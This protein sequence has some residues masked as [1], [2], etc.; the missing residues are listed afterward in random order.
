MARRRFRPDQKTVRSIT[1]R[2]KDDEAD[3]GAA[4]L[5]DLRAQRRYLCCGSFNLPPATRS[6]VVRIVTVCIGTGPVG[7]MVI[8][9]LPGQV[10]P[11][12]AILVMAGLGL[13]G[14]SLV[15]RKLITARQQLA[16]C[17]TNQTAM[18]PCA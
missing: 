10:G 3:H 8:G 9:I 5:G 4:P 15:C 11:P 12:V 17:A 1:Q 6:R 18:P 16:W 13:C 14:L 2:R 7:V